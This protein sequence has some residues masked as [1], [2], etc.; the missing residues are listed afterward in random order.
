M[1]KPN[2]ASAFIAVILI[3]FGIADLSAASLDEIPALEYWLNNVPMRLIFLFGLTAYTYLFKEGGM[4]GPEVA[5]GS[6][7]ELLH[8]SLVFSWAFF[9]LMAWFWVGISVAGY[10]CGSTDTRHRCSSV[11]ETSGGISRSALWSAGRLRR[12]AYEH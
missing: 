7:G 3:F 9:E 4:L 11:Y 10:A 2:E 5:S 1:D 12:T 6:V 8:N